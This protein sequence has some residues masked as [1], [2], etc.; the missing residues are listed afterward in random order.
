MEAVV[1]E[2]LAGRSG[3]VYGDGS[4]YGDASGHGYGHGRGSGSGTG[5]GN[6]SNSGTGYGY[7]YGSGRGSGD[8]SGY[9]YG[10]GRGYG[11]GL[12]RVSGYDSDDGSGDGIQAVSKRPVYQIDGVPTILNHIH[13]NIAEGFILQSDLTLT[14]CYVVKE[15]GKFVH[16]A[17]LREAFDGL[18]EKPYDDRTEEERLAAFGEH[19][20]DF[21]KKYP[22]KALFAWHHVLTGS[23]KA[24][25]EAFC[26]DRGI[27]LDKDRYTVYEFILQTKDS[28]GGHI[29]QRL[30]E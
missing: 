9:G 28:Y 17:T 18:Q 5:T 23:C 12:G 29:I 16:G 15:N 11:Y 20:P 1:S 24:G 4:G 13:G 7:G 26:R 21:D 30:I 25:R 19:F 8:G 10:L 2:F 3:Y 27:D 14:P 6:A 22:A